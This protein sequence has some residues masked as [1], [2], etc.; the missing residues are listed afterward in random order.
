MKNL[1]VK[2]TLITSKKPE[3][4]AKKHYLNDKNEYVCETSAHMSS[5]IAKTITINSATEF[6]EILKNANTNNAICGG[7][8]DFDKVNIV[9]QNSFHNQANTITRTKEYFHFNENSPGIL[10]LDYDPPKNSEVLTKDDFIEAI[11]EIIPNFYHY[12]FVWTTSSSSLI[13]HNDKKINGIKGQ[14]LYL[15][16]ENADDIPRAGKNLHARLW[17]QGHGYYTIS[18]SGQALERSIIDTSIWQPNHLDFVGGAHCTAPILQKP[19]KF[20]INEGK[21]FDTLSFLPEL[22]EEEIQQL[23]KI[24]SQKKLLIKDEIS[25]KQHIYRK[26]TSLKILQ[27]KNPHFTEYTTEEILDAEQLVEN[28]FNKVLTSD[29]VIMLADH[30]EVTVDEILKNPKKYHNSLTLDPLEPEYK[31]FKVIGKIYLDSHQKSIHSF[32]HGG[33]T[34]KLK[35]ALKNIQSFSGHQ[36]KLTD[37]TLKHMKESLEFFDCNDQLVMLDDNKLI[38]INKDNLSYYIST[39]IQYFTI[40]KNNEQKYINPPSEL[41]KQLL[42]INRKLNKISTVTDMPIILSNG[43]IISSYGYHEEHEIFISH[44][45]ESFPE[46]KNI[47]NE[48]LLQAI[49]DLIYP[50]CEFSFKTQLDFSVTLA[51]ILTTITRPILP[52][53]PAFSIDAPIQGTGKSYLGQCLSVLAT[54]APPTTFPPNKIKNDDELRKKITGSLLNNDRTIL[55]DNIVDSFDSP[56]LATFLTSEKYTDRLLNQNINV[57]FNNRLLVL[58][59]GNNI[60]LAGDMLRRVLK[61]RLDS[62]MQDPYTRSFKHSPLQYIKRNRYKLVIA[63]LTIIKA[64]FESEYFHNN[65]HKNNGLLSSFEEW[66]KLVRQPILWLSDTIDSNKF[67]DPVDSIKQSMK[68]DPDTQAW[69]RILQELD[70]INELKDKWLEAKEILQIILNSSNHVM[71]I[72]LLQDLLNT[73]EISHRN[74]GKAL[75]FRKDKVVN[76]LRIIQKQSSNR[77]RYKLEV[78]NDI[79]AVND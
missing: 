24:K 11:S 29:F 58:L 65:Q 4:L 51:A 43:E 57:T 69:S 47:S 41:I 78:I 35:P 13:F 30:T 26:E 55:L 12:S 31:N 76:N 66:D 67:Q 53:T 42:S 45:H 74:F 18:K 3:I 5:G 25:C 37:Q 44:T 33:C 54:A 75:S 48:K 61:C 1:N 73:D 21:S 15:F 46:L 22:T 7:I 23:T 52:T 39:C 63:G 49:S 79:N 19:R 70:Q 40:D 62:Q 50:F 6:A 60:E 17:L 56:T 71:I 10:I 77:N 72:E 59:T 9:S 28:S 20:E 2:F 34:Y 14:R 68:A 64:Y 27:Y 36:K 16:V 8:T 32:A 38:V